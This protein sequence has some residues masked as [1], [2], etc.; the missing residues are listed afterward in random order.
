MPAPSTP[1]ICTVD[2]LLTLHDE[3]LQVIAAA[4][5]GAVRRA[6]GLPGGYIHAQHDQDAWDAAGRAAREDRHRQP[7]LEQL[8]TFSG[9]GRDPR[10]W[11]LSIAITP[12]CR[13][14]VLPADEERL[15]MWPVCCP[16]TTAPSSSWRWRGC[17]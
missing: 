17:A 10:G 16:S 15:R 3:R 4:R 11:S 12:W 13:A 1:I 7:Y 5:A 14:Y 9:P 6:S 2:G 8:A